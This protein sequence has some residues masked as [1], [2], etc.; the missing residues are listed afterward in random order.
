MGYGT[1]RTTHY[2]RKQIQSPLRGIKPRGIVPCAMIFLITF[3]NNANKFFHYF[4]RSS[5]GQKHPYDHA[6]LLF[7]RSKNRNFKVLKILLLA[8]RGVIENLIILANSYNTINVF[9][10]KPN[11]YKSRLILY[12]FSVRNYA[13]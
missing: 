4:A 3:K 2:K 13:L 1:R 12:R 8:L 9:D 11:E 7:A 6:S 10:C 5:S